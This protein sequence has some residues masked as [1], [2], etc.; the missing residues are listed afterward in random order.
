MAGIIILTDDYGS[1]VFLWFWNVSMILKCFFYIPEVSWFWSVF[2]FLPVIWDWYS[3]TFVRPPHSQYS[4][5]GKG[6][7]R[8]KLKQ[9]GIVWQS[10][11]FT[12]DQSQDSDSSYIWRKRNNLGL[13]QI[14][15]V[16][17]EIAICL[18]V[19]YVHTCI[20]YTCKHWKSERTSVTDK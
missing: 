5:T 8:F 2:T 3:K 4:G 17:S 1:D 11:S 15:S 14:T 19:S 16:F 20:H 18:Y 13:Y 12:K 9:Y 6:K 7:H 10:S